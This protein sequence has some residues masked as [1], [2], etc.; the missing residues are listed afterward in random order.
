MLE[1]SEIEHAH[2]AVGAAGDEDVNAVGAEADVKNFFVVGDKLSLGGE[3]W[4]IP[5]RAGGV[6]GRCNDERW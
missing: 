1:T 5:D 6:N 3:G 2:A 4:D